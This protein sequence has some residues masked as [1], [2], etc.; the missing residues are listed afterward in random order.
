MLNIVFYSLHAKYSMCS[1]F[2]ND[3][4]DWFGYGKLKVFSHISATCLFL[5]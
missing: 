2:A 3:V 4:N 5:Y 1:L